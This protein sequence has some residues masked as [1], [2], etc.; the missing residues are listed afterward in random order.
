MERN[1]ADGMLTTRFRFFC[2]L[3]LFSLPFLFFVVWV[4]RK[5]TVSGFASP[6]PPVGTRTTCL[7]GK[8]TW[9]EATYAA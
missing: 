1:L 4:E 6:L 5:W 3:F 9:H 2:L 7:K 8:L